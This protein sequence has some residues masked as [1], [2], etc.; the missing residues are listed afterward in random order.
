MQQM[1]MA[2]GRYACLTMQPIENQIIEI[3]LKAILAGVGRRRV[4]SVPPYV[5]PLKRGRKDGLTPS[6]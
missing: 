6:Q 5:S 4:A 2:M 1:D 3:G